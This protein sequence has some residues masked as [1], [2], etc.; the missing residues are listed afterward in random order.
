MRTKSFL[1]SFSFGV[2]MDIS[3]CPVRSANNPSI[4]RLSDWHIQQI[5]TL[6]PSWQH[7]HAFLANFEELLDLSSEDTDRLFDAIYPESFECDYE[8]DNYPKETC[9]NG[10]DGDGDFYWKDM[11]ELRS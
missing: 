8:D 3:S 11:S 10:I 1:L 7:F 4:T 9:W 5:R 6:V 2:Q